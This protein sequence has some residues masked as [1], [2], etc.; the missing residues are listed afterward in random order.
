MAR[1]FRQQTADGD[2]WLHFSPNGKGK[3]RLLTED[4]L[5]DLPDDFVLAANF[6]EVL[7]QKQIADLIDSNFPRHD[8]TS[9]WSDIFLKLHAGEHHQCS[10]PDADQIIVPITRLR[11]FRRSFS[12]WTMELKR[13]Q[14]FLF[15]EKPQLLKELW[16]SSVLELAGYR[17][18]EPFFPA[19]QRKDPSETPIVTVI[20]DIK[21]TSQ[22]QAYFKHK[23][24]LNTE[25]CGMSLTYLD[26]EIAPLRT[27]GGQFSGGQP[28][29][30]TGCGG[31][32]LLLINRNRICVGEIKIRDDSELF[33]ALLQGLWYASELAT[34]NQIER[35]KSVYSD[36]LNGVDLDASGIDVVILSIDQKANDQ[37]RNATIELVNWI[38]EFGNFNRLGTV[39]LLENHGDDWRPIQ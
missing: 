34:K 32:D 17:F 33:D 25:V 7:T 26:R 28:A 11:E 18:I 23:F 37:T 12:S 5:S 21:R 22:A 13:G 1:V 29:T 4:G 9:A 3:Y 27:P 14:A 35:I 19:G 30:S 2:A 24:R 39:H 31:A 15:R 36:K 16:K 10:R 6:A 8:S 38:N 20:A